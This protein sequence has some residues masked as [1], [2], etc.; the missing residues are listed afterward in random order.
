VLAAAESRR[1]GGDFDDLPGARQTR[2]RTGSLLPSG[3]KR[4]LPLAGDRLSRDGTESRPS[5]GDGTEGGG[6][7]GGGEGG[8]VVTGGAAA[9]DA[10]GSPGVASISSHGER[11]RPRPG[12]LSARLRK[13]ARLESLVAVMQ[14][15]GAGVVV[16]AGS[17]C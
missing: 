4:L 14:Y 13:R 9:S 16:V 17:S 6:T 5:T 15:R 8:G 10:C 1:T 12:S 2:W 3:R 7:K 11:A